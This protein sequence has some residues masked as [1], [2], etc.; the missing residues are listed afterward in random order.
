MVSRESRGRRSVPQ[1]VTSLRKKER[2]ASS[3]R[4]RSFGPVTSPGAVAKYPSEDR[5]TVSRERSLRE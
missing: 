4:L 1:R 3:G 2:A 5:D